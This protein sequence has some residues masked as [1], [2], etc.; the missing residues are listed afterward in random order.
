[1]RLTRLSTF[2][3]LLGG[4]WFVAHAD[5]QPADPQIAIDAGSLSSAF[6]YSSTCSASPTDGGG[7]CD[8]FNPYGSTITQLE[9]VVQVDV[10]GLTQSGFSWGNPAQYP[11]SSP[12]FTCESPDVFTTCLIAYNPG[13]LQIFFYGTDAAHPGILPLP[14]GCSSNPDAPG[15]T[16][17]GHFAVDLNDGNA[18]T[19]DI[20]TWNTVDASPFS[21]QFIDT[22]NGPIPDPS[23]VPEPSMA[24]MLAAGCLLIFAASRVNAIAFR[25][26]LRAPAVTFRRHGF[27]ASIALLA[28]FTPSEEQAREEPCFTRPNF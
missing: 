9:F 10:P 17:T 7:F 11:T 4:F 25:R 23:P 14:P 1:M 5:V 13:E 22:V 2:A 21:V 18:K 27:G 19:G 8:F 20:G 16:T 6:T 26:W 28:Y 3:A 12:V 15:C 24:F